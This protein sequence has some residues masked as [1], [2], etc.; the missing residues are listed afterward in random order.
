MILAW[1][2]TAPLIGRAILEEV[3]VCRM[4]RNICWDLATT[5]NGM[6]RES[7]ILL[8]S[9][10]NCL[11]SSLVVGDGDMMASSGEGDETMTVGAASWSEVS[12]SSSTASPG[13]SEGPGI[14]DEGECLGLTLR[15]LGGL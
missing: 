6:S 8:E 5:S 2:M 7:A 12:S 1:S 9:S 11:K 10:W 13:A 4:S 15:E 3:E 14:K